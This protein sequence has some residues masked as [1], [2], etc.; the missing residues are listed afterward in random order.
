MAAQHSD[1]CFGGLGFRQLLA[2]AA[3]ANQQ[4]RARILVAVSG[5]DANPARCGHLVAVNEG[6]LPPE[7][8]GDAV[9]DGIEPRR[10]GLGGVLKRVADEYT[11]E[12]KTA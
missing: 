7:L 10:D 9:L 6:K 12:K 4:T 1:H 2:V 5:V 11:P 8:R 3:H